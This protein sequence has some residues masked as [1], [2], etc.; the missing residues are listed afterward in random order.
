MPGY[1]STRY[2]HRIGRADTRTVRLRC[3][4]WLCCLLYMSLAFRA[5]HPFPTIHSN[6]DVLSPR[7]YPLLYPWPI[8]YPTPY[9]FNCSGAGRYEGFRSPSVIG[10]SRPGLGNLEA[11]S[12]RTHHASCTTCYPPTAPYHRV[13]GGEGS[14]LCREVAARA[15]FDNPTL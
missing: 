9:F 2:P 5:W 1:T 14:R 10:R 15:R 4:L 12:H 11:I 3:F 7:S 8:H 6:P 13:F